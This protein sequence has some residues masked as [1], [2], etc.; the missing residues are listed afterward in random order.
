MAGTHSWYLQGTNRNQL[1]NGVPFYRVQLESA[2]VRRVDNGM[3]WPNNVINNEKETVAV[4]MLV[5]I[6][7]GF[8]PLVVTYSSCVPGQRTR[9]VCVVFCVFFYLLRLTLA[10][11]RGLRNPHI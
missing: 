4:W 1:V 9:V 7:N 2:L 8:V 10:V 11:H 6:R 5:R 3:R